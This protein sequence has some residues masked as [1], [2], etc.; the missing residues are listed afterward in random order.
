MREEERFDAAISC[1]PLRLKRFA[2]TLS[3]EEK[4]QT[5]EIRLRTG[6]GMTLLRG[7]KEYPVGEG[8]ECMVQQ[9]DLETV[10]MKATR[11]RRLT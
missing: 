1:L 10:C 3:R 8:A 5:E 7:G 4:Q 11:R 9:E 6:Q 2:Q